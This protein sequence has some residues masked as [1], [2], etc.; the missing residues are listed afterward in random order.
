MIVVG[1]WLGGIIQ[2]SWP[3]VV[4]VQG[5]GLSRVL[6]SLRRSQE[7]LTGAE[8]ASRTVPDARHGAQLVSGPEDHERDRALM[9]LVVD[10]DEAALTA[11]YDRY[12]PVVNGLARSILRDPA[13]AEEATH[14]VF[15]RLWLQPAAYDPA[16]GTFAGWL[17]RV[18]RNRAIDVLRRRR[19]DP[20]SALGADVAGWLADPEPGP[21]EQALAGLRRDEVR[22]A[23]ETL[24]PDHRQLLEL[25][26]FTGLSQSQ[27]AERLD[28]PLGTVKSQVRAAM[29]RLAERLVP[30]DDYPPTRP[31]DAGEHR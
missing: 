5:R 15:L 27:I 9:R 30:A 20:E 29:A 10:R 14:D 11:L 21:E 25:A 13:L 12:A 2:P 26:Y 24:S 16:R 4:K 17:L 18:A 23:L 19:E 22:R 8:E 7:T 28:R 31:H 1:G 3:N 6:A